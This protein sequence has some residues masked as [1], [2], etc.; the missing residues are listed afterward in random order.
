MK[1][2]EMNRKIVGISIII[3]FVSIIPLS[4]VHELG[5]SYICMMEGYTFDIQLGLDGG[6]MVCHGEVE[7]Q[8]LFRA[9][10]GVLAGT[11]AII[12]LVAFRQIR[13]Y[14]AVVIALLP[15]GLGHYLNAGIE[16]VFY[17][18]YMQDSV[19]WGMMMGLFAFLMFI[20]LATKYAKKK[21]NL[22]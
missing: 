22:L 6:R 4:Y 8:I 2:P 14:P 18:T 1:L 19:I 20:G 3:F 21:V 17:K 5:H 7:N 10:G 9:I 15:L 11:A 12:P 13:K 16:T